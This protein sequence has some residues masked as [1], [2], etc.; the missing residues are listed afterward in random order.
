M[1]G[2]QDYRSALSDLSLASTNLGASLVSDPLELIATK[3]FGIQI[4]YTGSPVGVLELQSSWDRVNWTPIAFSQQQINAAPG[5]HAWNFQRAA[6][7]FVRVAW[8]RT[9]G[10][11]TIT[12][13]KFFLRGF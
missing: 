13:A 10:S 12:S 5:T 6:F 4:A 7:P 2:N 9:S 1:R 3:D 11:G 8:N